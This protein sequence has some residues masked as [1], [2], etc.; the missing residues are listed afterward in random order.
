M[1]SQVLNIFFGTQTQ[2][3]ASMLPKFVVRISV[4]YNKSLTLILPNKII[5]VWS[6][7]YIPDK[8]I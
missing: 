7:M 3:Y 8:T 1:T 5:H 4:H 2:L 6:K